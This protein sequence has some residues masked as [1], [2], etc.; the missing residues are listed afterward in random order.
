[1]ANYLVT[2]ASAAVIP[3]G[4]LPRTSLSL[5]LELQDRKRTMASSKVKQSRHIL[6][7]IK[8]CGYANGNVHVAVDLACL[9]AK[10]GNEVTFI[11]AGGTFVPL[12]ESHGVCHITLNHDQS[13]PL[14]LLRTMWKVTRF[15]RKTRP[16]VMNAH[17]MSSALVGWVASHLSGVPLVTTVHNSFDKHSSIM[18]LGRRVIAVS[19]AERASLIQKGYRSDQVVAV[20]NAPAESPR[21]AFM[22]DGREIILQSPAI[23]AI[24]AL[25]RRK[26]VFDLIEAC[27]GLFQTLPDWKLYIAGEGPD[28][29]VLEQQA[30]KAGL[31]DRIIFLG[32]VP[33]PGR[34]LKQADIVV[35]ASYADPCSLV[36]G[37]ARAAGCAIVATDVGGN[38]EMLEFGR[39]GRLVPAGQP[40][41]L[42]SVLKPLMV[43]SFE[44]VALQR[45]AR[46]GASVFHVERL[47]A[48]YATVYDQAREGRA[49]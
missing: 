17:M 3:V 28:R 27:T 21:E 10:A 14:S 6:H 38:K 34:L 44:R 45:A 4:E 30:R 31:T 15:V 24:N 16:Y 37:E 5:L 25:H 9:Q 46:K 33:A 29:E 19:Q 49:A 48:D 12:L 47:V 23:L 26:G 41:I 32:F 39:A 1:M 35:L 43:D 7:I 36:I 20:M 8:H 22:D 40:Q 2:T 18:R 11:S 13:K 42:A